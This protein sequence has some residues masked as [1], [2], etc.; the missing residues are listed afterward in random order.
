[1]PA[2]HAA[3][4]SLTRLVAAVVVLP[5]VIGLA[6]LGFAWPTG[7]LAPRDIPV[8]VVGPS[9]AVQATTAHL[10]A[11]VPGAF[12]LRDYPST[13]AAR[14]AIRHRDVYGALVVGGGAPTVLEAS[15]ASPA[16]AQ[17]LT[18]VGG[19]LAA[20]QAAATGTQP[21]AP[22]VLDLVPTSS[23]DPKGLVFSSAL[24]RSAASSSPA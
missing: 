15:A 19:K 14:T 2:H 22:R 21:A 20:A 13:Q 7:R 8:G 12:E 24:L 23:E 4:R 11:S 5:F 3:D 18:S 6:V 9:P 16:V 1:M 10:R 17:L